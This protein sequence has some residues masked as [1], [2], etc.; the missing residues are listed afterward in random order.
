MSWTEAP[1]SLLYKMNLP[2]GKLFG[3]AGA[4]FGYG[5]TGN[6]EKAGK[7]TNCL[8]TIQIGSAKILACVSQV[9]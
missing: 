4:A 1:V 5:V 3:G 8:V 7:K 6:L 9:V 2:F